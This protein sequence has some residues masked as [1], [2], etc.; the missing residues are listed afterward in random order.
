MNRNNIKKYNIKSSLFSDKA[1]STKDLEASRYSR[2]DI[3]TNLSEIKRN[4]YSYFSKMYDND[5]SGIFY[6]IRL[7]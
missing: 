2:N 4:D 5:K 3:S 7:N 6:I 1:E